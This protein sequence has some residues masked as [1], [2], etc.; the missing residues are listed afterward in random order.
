MAF[1]VFLNWT[2][3]ICWETRWT[4]PSMLFLTE[5]AS[6]PSLCL[7]SGFDKLHSGVTLSCIFSGDQSICFFL[8]WPPQEIKSSHSKRCS[9]LCHM[10]GHASA[11][12]YTPSTPSVCQHRWVCKSISMMFFFPE[13]QLEGRKSFECPVCSSAQFY[14][15][16][17]SHDNPFCPSALS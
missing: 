15:L 9:Q 17:P 13:N 8:W 3:K 10:T 7:G 2:L 4:D 14:G 1:P 6:F 5:Q 16:S 11:C 12:L